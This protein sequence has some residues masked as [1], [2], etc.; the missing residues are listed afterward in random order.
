MKNKII[1]RWII[2]GIMWIGALFL[3][4]W[5]G[6]ITKQTKR[7]IEQ[8]E[9]YKLE[10]RSFKSQSENISKIIKKAEN[11][12]Q[13]VDAPNIGILILEK[14]LHFLASNYRLTQI[15]IKIDQT[16]KSESNALLSIAFNGS[17]KNTIQWL[18]ALQRDFPYIIVR[19][20]EIIQEPSKKQAK[21]KVSLN[22]RYRIVSSGKVI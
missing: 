8:E 20:L 22:Y 10:N 15:N 17:L 13:T 18:T 19:G 6:E 7:I 3:A 2:V 4:Y 11:L 16:K 14:K 5:N 9:I 1:K 12:Y 21:F